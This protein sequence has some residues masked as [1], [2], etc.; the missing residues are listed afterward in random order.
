M[1]KS[2]DRRLQR[3]ST[4]S[5]Y[6]HTTGVYCGVMSTK[7]VSGPHRR[8]NITLPERTVQLLDRVADKGN[9]SRLIAAAVE[10]YVQE[11][12]RARLRSLLREGAVTHAARDLEIAEEWF[13]IDEQAW[14][15]KRK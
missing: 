5:L 10:R 8:L 9:R 7:P 3:S 1:G 15:A 14:P 12:G 2:V 11:E 13:L 6:I 4:T